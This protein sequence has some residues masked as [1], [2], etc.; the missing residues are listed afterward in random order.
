M[1]IHL[2]AICGTGMGALAVMLK[3]IGHRVTGSD[4]DVYPPMSTVLERHGIP[5]YQPFDAA[6]LDPAPDLV[7]IGNAVSRGNP[8][9][10]ATLARRIRYVSMPEALKEFFLW[11]KRPVVVT[12]THGK[13]TTTALLTWMLD[14]A[15]YDPN[16]IIGGVPVGWESGARLGQG[17]LFILEGD[18]Y[19][20][21]F[22]D[23]RAKFLHYLPEIVLINNIEYDH[24]DIYANLDE[25]RLAF[26]RLINIIPGNGLLV[27]T[28]DD[29]T[30]R[31]LLPAAHCPVQTFGLD[32]AA[33]WSAQ[34]I[35][36][37]PAGTTF[38]VFEEGRS[39][40]TV[41]MPLYGAHNVHNA[42]GAIAAAVT[43]KVPWE[44]IVE[45]LRV[46]PG[47]KR[48]LEVR[49][50]VRGISVYDDF[51]HHP[52]AVDATLRALRRAYP[53]HRIW[54]VFEP[55]TAAT[56]RSVFQQAYAGAFDAA[57]FVVLAPVFNP[58]KAP[59][60]NRFS[61]EQ[62][63]ADLQRR[64]KNAVALPDTGAIVAHLKACT[65]P[66]DHVVFMSNGGFDGIHEKFLQAL[67][68]G[69]PP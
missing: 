9:A 1:H 67:R 40:G 47:I 68:A 35:A 57:D 45:G 46:F 33:R 49:G 41:S 26:Q 16:Y 53:D 7:V 3:S 39:R 14:R 36:V 52:T 48:R 4:R 54:A 11:K 66:D 28:A 56:I 60:G 69:P 42:L 23:K 34:N 58:H 18:E 37:S 10:E 8:E 55:R 24:A 20:S 61:V 19:D 6:H 2:I 59:E 62:L 50:V 13:T 30:V 12:G 65:Q 64:G 32:D 22:F 17:D 5:V 31:A 43:L 44:T 38:E 15:G 27:A 51:A 63:T 21:A 29:A 25:I